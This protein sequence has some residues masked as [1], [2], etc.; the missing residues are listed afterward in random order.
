[1][2]IESLHLK[3]SLHYR[4]S[5][6]PQIDFL[7]NLGI[8]SCASLPSLTAGLAFIIMGPA[9]LLFLTYCGIDVSINSCPVY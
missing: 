3:Y 2:E 6:C 9:E 8:G 4:L 5:F 7:S 1:M